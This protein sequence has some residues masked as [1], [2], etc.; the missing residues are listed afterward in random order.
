MPNNENFTPVYLFTGFLEAGKTTFMRQTLNDPRFNTG[1][2][3]LVILCEEGEEELDTLALAKTNVNVVSVDGPEELN[4]ANIR[5]FMAENDAKRILIEY[6]GMWQL[7]DLFDALPEDCAV[8]QEMMFADAT[9]FVNYDQNMRS[10][11]V[12]K[13]RTA[14]IVIFNRYN[15]SID[16]M[17][18]HKICRGVSRGINIA[19]EYKDGKVKYDDIQDP[20]PFDINAPVIKIEDRDYALWYRDIMEEPKKYDGKTVTFKGLVA[21]DP[22]FPAGAFAVGRHVMTCCVEDIQYMAIAADWEKADTLASRDWLTVTGKVV[23]E[24]SRLYKGKGP[25][26]HVTEA[27]KA[28]PPA[29]EVATFY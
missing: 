6:N 9:T 2:A 3:T 20:L 27:S 12:D 26:L 21:T 17:T 15:D 29:Q 5:R 11:V 14:E 4:E 10:L 18:L 25:V 19:Y 16:M 23:F 13:L 22:K 24:R 1:E 7:K 28:E 8:Y